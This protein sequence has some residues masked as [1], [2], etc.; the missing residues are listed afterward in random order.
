MY[1]KL[2]LVSSIFMSASLFFLVVM[3]LSIYLQ[4]MD[5]ANY[6]I[7]KG[8]FIFTIAIGTSSLL[9]SFFIRYKGR[10]K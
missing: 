9:D 7:W 5:I 4:D 3:L 6:L 10:K 1:K 2:S 8:G